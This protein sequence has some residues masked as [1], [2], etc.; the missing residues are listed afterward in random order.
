MA[1]LGVVIRGIVEAGAC[2]PLRVFCAQLSHRLLDLHHRRA[3]R[4]TVRTQVLAL[5]E[6]ETLLAAGGFHKPNP[7]QLSPPGD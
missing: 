1:Y 7:D 6:H 4:A 5:S 3:P 2:L